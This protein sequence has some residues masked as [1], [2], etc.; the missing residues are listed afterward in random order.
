M[1]LSSNLLNCSAGLPGI[2]LP[3][4]LWSERFRNFVEAGPIS[5]V[6]WID[7]L[8]PIIGSHHRVQ[9]AISSARSFYR[10]T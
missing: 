1:A 3:R 10:L 9:P 7:G 5:A 6:R 8:T 4:L 2:E